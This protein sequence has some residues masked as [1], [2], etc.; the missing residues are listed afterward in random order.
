M[1]TDSKRGCAGNL[2]LSLKVILVFIRRSH[3]GRRALHQAWEARASNSP[4]GCRLILTISQSKDTATPRTTSPASSGSQG[5][6][7]VV[8]T[9]SPTRIGQQMFW[10]TRSWRDVPPPRP[11]GD[12]GPAPKAMASLVGLLLCDGRPEG[13]LLITS[14][15]SR[16]QAPFRGSRR[17]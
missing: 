16:S 15:S 7:R 17:A 12:K 10:L 5:T 1:L 6:R 14:Y 2:G 13:L 4:P 8:F 3:A 9:Y 11:G